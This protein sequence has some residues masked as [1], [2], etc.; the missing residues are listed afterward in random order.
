MAWVCLGEAMRI[1]SANWV[2]IAVVVVLGTM[3]MLSGCGRKDALYIPEE[4]VD[5]AV[6]P[7]QVE[8]D[9][10]EQNGKKVQ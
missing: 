7:H 10:K 6:S 1:C 4:R 5:T 3:S 2:L 8:T 9:N